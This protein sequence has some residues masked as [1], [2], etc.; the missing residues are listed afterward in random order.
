[1]QRTRIFLD[2]GVLTMNPTDL[3]VYEDYWQARGDRAIAASLLHTHALLTTRQQTLTL[4]RRTLRI[5]AVLL[6]E[7]GS[8]VDF[9]RHHSRV[10]DYHRAYGRLLLQAT[11]LA[12]RVDQY[13]MSA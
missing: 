1:M 12:K 9:Q 4:V 10:A 3:W 13:S 6:S 11:R 2:A 7:S 5:E 8:D